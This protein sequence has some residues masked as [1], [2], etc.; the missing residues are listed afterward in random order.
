MFDQKQK[1]FGEEE[2]NIFPFS[3]DY[4]QFLSKVKTEREFVKEGIALAEKN[5]FRAA[6]SFSKYIPG[7]KIYYVNRK[8]NLVL[9]VI[10]QEDLEKGIHYVVS[11]I[12]SPRLD[13]K[14]NPLYEE[15]DLAYMKTHYYG[16][17]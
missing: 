6:E 11:H 4:R 14:A 12:D 17:S 3:E 16:R 13:L 2:K 7:D 9:A 1:W 15:L 8:K 10:G 5:G